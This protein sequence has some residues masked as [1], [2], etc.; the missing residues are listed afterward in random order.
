[1]QVYLDNSATT[2]PFPRVVAAMQEAL[3]ECWYNPSALYKP[4]LEAEKKVAAAREVC[5]KAVNAQGQRL[6]FDFPAVRRLTIWRSSDICAGCGSR[7][8]C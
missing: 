3:E 1:M 2:R 7:G 4:A 5:L 6:I 8:A